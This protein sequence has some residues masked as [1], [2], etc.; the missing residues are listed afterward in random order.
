[1]DRKLAITGTDSEEVPGRV[2]ALGR[3]M[4]VSIP[5]TL[6]ASFMSIMTFIDTAVLLGRLQT[7]AL[8]LTEAAARAQFGIYT[9]ALSVYN[10]PLA[11]IIPVS[12][13]IIPAIAAALA[14]GQGDEARSIMQSSVKLVNLLAMPA[15][16]GLMILATPILIALYNDD[17]QLTTTIMTILGAASFFACMQYITTAILQANGYERVALITFPIGAVL[18]IALTYILV[19]HSSFGI[20]GSPIGTLAC[21]AVISTLNITF[22]MIKIKER[23]KFGTVFFRPLLCSAVMAGAAFSVYRLIFWLGSGIIGT[24]RFAVTFYLAVAI[25]VGVAVY[26]VL[27]IVSR[28]ITMEDMKLVPKGEKVAKFLHIR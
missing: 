15:A 7:G 10:L 14:K 26:G 5:I 13:S 21:F 17:R 11:L 12:I 23:P 28:T 2:R 9:L 19:G 16:A 20:I 18:K 22:I 27:I 1:M 8:M 6:S 25:I 24:G 4:K 3:L